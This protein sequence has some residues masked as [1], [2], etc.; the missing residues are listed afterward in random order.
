MCQLPLYLAQ[1]PLNFATF[2]KCSFYFQSYFLPNSTRGSYDLMEGVY[3]NFW[4]PFWLSL[5]L[6]DTSDRGSGM[7]PFHKAKG[8]PGQQE[9]VLPQTPIASLLRMAQPIHPQKLL[10]HLS[11]PKISN[12]TRSLR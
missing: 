8:K 10:M 7:L 11:C 3:G 12:K 4:R 6:G 9:T 5:R 2:V 1:P